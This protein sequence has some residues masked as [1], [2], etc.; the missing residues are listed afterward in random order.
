MSQQVGSVTS[1]RVSPRLVVFIGVFFAATS[2]VLIKASAAHPLA[3]AFYRMLF[4]S[5]LLI[6]QLQGTGLRRLRSLSGRQWRLSIISGVF[7]GF[8]FATW[9]SSLSFTS[10]ASA[11]VLVNTHPVLVV[12]FGLLFLRERIPWD[13]AAWMILALA[14]SLL[15]SLAGLR[16]TEGQAVGNLLAFGGAIAA[17]GY[18]LA[19]R[20]VRQDVD[21]RVY[22]FVAYSVSAIVL[23]AMV[24]IGGVPLV[25]Y[26]WYEFLIF[27]GLAV[28]PTLL[29]HSLFNW[30]LKYVKT[31]LV[32]TAILGE[33]IFASI[34]ALLIFRE[35]PGIYTLIGGPVIIVSIYFFTRAESRFAR[36][37]VRA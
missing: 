18:M 35:I 1:P 22:T 15:L 4:S 32:S 27:M 8:H 5:L 20:A 16:G 3:I 19:G 24:L 26:P 25:G 23:L 17:A 12:V 10:V 6:P 34:M 37:S 29:G 13:A 11:T 30:A 36:R 31:S 21:T 2:A 7:L 28:F 9:I 33:P 14:G